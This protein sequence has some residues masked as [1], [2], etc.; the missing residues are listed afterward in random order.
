MSA[1]AEVADSAL[2]VPLLGGGSVRN[3]NLDLAASAPP[4]RVVAERVA[5][6]TPWYASVHRGSGF[7]SR[8]M[9][10]LLEESRTR[11]AELLGARADDAVIFTRNTTDAMNLLA[12]AIPGG[13][14]VL[15]IEHHATLL[16]WRSRRVLVAQ[17]T[18]AETLAVLEAELA[19]RPAA[20]LAV[21]AASNVTGERMPL[22]AFAELAH[23]HGARLCVDAAQLVPHRSID[24]AAL[25]IDYLAASGHK[26]YAPYGSGV[27]VG[28]ADW[29]DAAPP[30]QVGGGAIEHVGLDAV[31]WKTGAARHEGG[32]PNVLGDVAFTVALTAL[33]VIGDEARSAHDA[34]LL[35][36]LRSGLAR[37][38]GVRTLRGFQDD[39]DEVGIVTME[40]ETARVGILGAALAAEHGVAVRVGRFCAYP[41]YD[42]LGSR[43][44][45]LRVSV[46]LGTTSEDI[47][48][49]LVALDELL[50]HGPRYE[51]Q[52]GPDGWEPV[53]DDR[54]G[55]DTTLAS[56]L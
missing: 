39:L 32:T 41:F 31:Q 23:R 46:G 10:Q 24:I 50:R 29:L 9:T 44:N 33:A 36:H 35:A 16:P 42:R 22:A 6:L 18:I 54:P 51:Y 3:V 20:L 38:S 43:S 19:A 53:S 15:D 49:F 52:H 26:A 17:P 37:L 45:G 4:L 7:S 12:S 14:V 55:P 48:R 2:T 40:F 56:W 8:F 21:T 25:G 11:M 34:A 1:L 28:R 30:H 27:L 47:D 5:E 13:T